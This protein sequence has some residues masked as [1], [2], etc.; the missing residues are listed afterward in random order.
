M[1]AG[2]AA[3]LFV[4]VD[5]QVGGAIK[6]LNEVDRAVHTVASGR[7]PTITP[8][9]DA[10]PAVSAL[11]S[12][13]AKIA[14]S[15]MGQGLLGG[16]VG[17]ATMA[18]ASAGIMAVTSAVSG[19]AS[20]M[21]GGAMTMEKY[22]VQ[23]G[24]LLGSTS[25]AQK[26]IAEL[27]EFAKTTPF[28]LPEVVEASKQLQVFTKGALA[29]G[30]GLRLV[31]DIASGTGMM[32]G[33]AAMWIGR[34]YDA[35][36]S[37]RPIGEAAMR[38]QEVGA[39]SGESRA[40]LEQLAESVKKGAL[41]GTQ[42]WKQAAGEFTRYSGMMA[43]QS[44]TLEGKMSNLS[45][46]VNMLLTKAGTIFL[47]VIKAGV[48][49]A[50]ASLSLLEVTLQGILLPFSG[51]TW[52]GVPVSIDTITRAA[53][54]QA[55]TWETV[56]Q[57]ARNYYGVLGA[58]RAE[59][60]ATAASFQSFRAAERDSMVGAAQDLI[61]FRAAER[62]S[63]VAGRA[64]VAAAAKNYFR[65]LLDEQAKAVDYMIARAAR[66]PSQLAD[67]LL[68]DIA[69]WKSA[70]EALNT[71]TKT[72]MTKGAKVGFL[73]AALNGTAIREGLASKK[74]EVVAEARATAQVLLDAL[75]K[76]QGPS[77]VAG[78]NF[79]NSA[80]QGMVK[81]LEGMNA[82]MGRAGGG[83]AQEAADKAAGKPAKAA[84][85]GVDWYKEFMKGINSASA[86]GGAAAAATAATKAEIAS[87][88]EAFATLGRS[89]LTIPDF[90]KSAAYQ[91]AVRAY[92]GLSAASKLTGDAG[93]AAMLKITTALDRANTAAQKKIA[94][95]QA[96]F[97]RLKDSIAAWPY[98]TAT[99]V[100]NAIQAV[101][102]KLA[103]AWATLDAQQQANAIQS[104]ASE[105]MRAAE[106]AQQPENVQAIYRE[107]DAQTELIK[108]WDAIADKA[109]AGS[110]E[111][112]DAIQ[113]AIDAATER[114]RLE[115][116]A[117]ETI[118]ANTKATNDYAQALD[119]Q[120]EATDALAQAQAQA[121]EGYKAPTAVEQA[122][123]EKAA[124]DAAVAATG[125][126]ATTPATIPG[127]VMGAPTIPGVL[128]GGTAKTTIVNATVNVTGP[129]LDPYGDF[130]QRLAAALIP[131]LQREL[132]R[133]GITL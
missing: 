89:M 111:Q 124:A 109:K 16:L 126:G 101:T 95:L 13:K 30:E 113:K 119:R 86:G 34:L 7:Q 64:E 45:D 68:S 128:S 65:P 123:A 26:R 15:G 29:T 56:A 74:P 58:T 35:L 99:G 115:K 25:A 10:A 21:I 120:R 31:G 83:F 52:A 2:E 97:S 71:V 61:N 94:E 46:S 103:A 40:R 106:I 11:N 72:A 49:G 118:A 48:D 91:G 55:A 50:I 62:A 39:L 88:K 98:M 85:T 24:V 19:L 121:Q 122:L 90:S 131:G 81:G 28:E 73:L 102:D 105:R 63:F 43:K 22:T 80:V 9:V 110:K 108:K 130:A 4:T 67:A 6:G 96:A 75:T 1:A 27:A 66:T 133:Q 84:A 125:Q 5:A 38:L 36:Q 117:E 77:W 53:D 51:Q 14:G 76:L 54:L 47:P 8:K 104:A 18:V 42:A 129:T 87:V 79:G 37:G 23:L 100:L 57:G 33:E 127:V 70:L 59:I 17:G 32:F 107:I 82:A 93:D 3:R 78:Y 44:E 12:L 112:Q 114:L 92:A 41:S 132:A 69:S 20:G 60:A 116:L